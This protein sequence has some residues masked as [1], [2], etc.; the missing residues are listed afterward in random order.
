MAKIV[1]MTMIAALGSVLVAGCA[2]FGGGG[3]DRTAAMTE[4]RQTAEE[5]R[6][7]A[8]QAAQSAEEAQAA[9]EQAAASAQAAEERANRMFQMSQQKAG[10]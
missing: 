3:E 9:A 2:V 1:R 5:A 10:M 6:Q 4:S 8:A 7:Q